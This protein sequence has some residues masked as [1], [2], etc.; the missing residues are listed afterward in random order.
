M[1][2]IP[3]FE[4][5]EIIGNFDIDEEGNYIIISNG[6]D[7][8]G[9]PRLEDMD[10]HRVNKRGYLINDHG[11]VVTRDKTIIFRI[12]EVDEDDEVPAPFCYY[13]NKD[14]LGLNQN[15]M[16]A[17]MFGPNGQPYNSRAVVHE[18]EEEEDAVD[19][20]YQRLKYGMPAYDEA[21]S[22][23]SDD[24]ENMDASLPPS[25]QIKRLVQK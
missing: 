23:G 7:I 9:K 17:N 22:L 20:E 21:R 8:R 6:K 24:Q 13:K 14:S 25:K 10:G 4:I 3:K 1:N 15:N 18:Q 19:K 11:Q 2:Q 16:T 5:N 12:D